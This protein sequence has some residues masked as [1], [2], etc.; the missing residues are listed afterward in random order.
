MTTFAERVFGRSFGCQPE[1]HAGDRGEAL[2]SPQIDGPS[3][4]ILAAGR[5][6]RPSS[7]YRST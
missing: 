1:I 2:V 4:R 5:Q 7:T 3:G 6:E